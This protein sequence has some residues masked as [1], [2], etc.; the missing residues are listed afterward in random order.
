[1]PNREAMD[2]LAKTRNFRN[3]S[4][5]LA[6]I[7]AWLG[8]LLQPCVMAAG[9]PDSTVSGSAVELSVVT[10]HGPADRC[11]HCV[12]SDSAAASSVSGC[13]ETSAAAQTTA[14]KGLDLGDDT[15][16]PPAITGPEPG[17]DCSRFRYI[18]VPCAEDLP[19]PV[20]L[21]VL[22]CVFLE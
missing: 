21:T 11:L 20:S 19:R 10:H 2:I 6:T 5:L 18:G 15:W 4:A 8:F 14:T 3:R 12:G 16:S 1:M 13:L 17:V 9:L 7:V 22:F